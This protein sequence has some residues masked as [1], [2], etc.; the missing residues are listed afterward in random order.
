MNKIIITNSPLNDG[1]KNKFSIY[2]HIEIK[3][4]D[5]I[6]GRKPAFKYNLKSK[7]INNFENEVDYK[8]IKAAPEFSGAK[9][10][11]ARGGSNKETI[12]L[13]VDCFKSLCMLSNNNIGKQTK[14]Y[15]LDLE[16]VFKIHVLQEFQQK[17][18]C[19]KFKTKGPVFYIITSGLEYKGCCSLLLWF[20]DS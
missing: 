16:K 1:L 3:N 11:D 12:F 2:N 6:L 8:V 17:H 19:Y 13:T 14:Q 15:Y 4:E 7:L 18:N 10:E 5:C 20:K 9:K